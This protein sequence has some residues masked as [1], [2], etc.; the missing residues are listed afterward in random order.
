MLADLEILNLPKVSLETKELLPE[1]S[2]IYYVVDE[3]KLV[4]YVGKA[5]NIHKRWKGKSHHRI[6]Q[7]QQLNHKQFYIYY[8]QV[9][10]S[11]LDKREKQQIEKYNPHLNNSPVKTKKV[12]PTE[13]LLR[14]TIAKIRDFAFILGVEPPRR[15]IKDKINIGW[16]IQERLLDLPIIHICLDLTAFKTLF[17][18]QSFNEQEALIK[19]IFSS[20]KAYASKWEGFPKGYPFMFRLYVNGFIVEVNYLSFWTENYKIEIPENYNYIKISKE[21]IKA[22]TLESLVA[23]QSNSL[24]Q[25][26]SKVQ[27]QRLK[28]Y[29]SDLIPLFFNESIDTQSAKKELEKISK[30]YKTGKRGLGSRSRPIKSKLINDDFTTIDDLLLLRGIDIY[31]YDRG[32]IITFKRGGRE[33]IG[34]YIQCFNLDP[35]APRKYSKTINGSEVPSYNSIVGIINNKKVT[36]PSYKFD[37]V[38]LLASVDKKAWLLVE[39]YLKDFA[40]IHKKINNVE[41]VTDKF[42]V[43]PR[44]FIVPAKVNIVLKKMRYSVW[45]PFG[46]NE[47]YPTFET[48]KQEIKK[49]LEEANL[50][51]LKLAF[52]KESIAK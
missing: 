7:L 11:Q 4:W 27:L 45:I 34:L 19:K 32:N 26:R 33:R 5:K 10:L 50:P 49:R 38:Y 36:S 52:K 8:E 20:R 42:Y 23:I 48:A 29:T 6:Y 37:R 30:D 25:Q 43:S 17:N 3:N 14:E 21:S 51:G 9:D 35:Q 46:M 24:I 16:L 44:K 28:P 47:Q 15:E 13:T 2:G 1:Y 18:P 31:K 40:T 41:G 12:R 39:N 22:L